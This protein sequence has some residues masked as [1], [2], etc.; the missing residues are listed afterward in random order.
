MARLW[1]VTRYA[2]R[3][4]DEEGFEI[5]AT[6]SPIIPLYVR[7]PYKTFAI[8]R[9]AFDRGVFINPVIPPACAAEDTLVRFA[10]MA[11]HTTEQVEE[12]VQILKRCFEEMEVIR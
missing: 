3:R 9:M 8:T 11:T 7:D 5:G 12:A 4:F 1:E 10:L 2:L 6:E